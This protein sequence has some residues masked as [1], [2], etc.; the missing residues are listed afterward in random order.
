MPQLQEW[1][2]DGHILRWQW[3]RR[4]QEQTPTPV[5]LS[6]GR[7]ALKYPGLAQEKTLGG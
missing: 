7:E 1:Q 3:N 4:L 6:E 2:L 5:P